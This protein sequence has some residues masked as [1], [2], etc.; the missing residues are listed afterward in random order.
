MPQVQRFHRPA[1]HRFFAVIWRV[2]GGLS[3]AYAL[4]RGYGEVPAAL[5]FLLCCLLAVL[6]DLVA[7]TLRPKF[8]AVPTLRRGRF[9]V[10]A[11]EADAWST[12]R[13]RRDTAE[14]GPD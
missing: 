1:R 12:P 14:P 11:D 7:A 3:A 5:I 13:G 4:Y 9:P 10:L 6:H 8:F 2:G